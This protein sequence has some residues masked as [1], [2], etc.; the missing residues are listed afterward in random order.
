MKRSYQQNCALAHALD[1]V[2]ERW[3]LLIVRELLI[4]PRRYGQLLDNLRGIGT[5]LLAD[6]LREMEARGLVEKH[7]QRYSLT[8]RGRQL[9]AVVFELVR[10]GLTLELED[11]EERLTRPEWDVVALNSLY[12]AVD[13]DGLGGRYVIELNASPFCIEGAGRDRV[14][15]TPGDCADADLRVSL[16]KKLARQLGN[17][18]RSFVDATRDG[19][20]RVQGS[21]REARRLLRSF[22]ILP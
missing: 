20:L 9:E 14:R 17:G 19:S 22:G 2:G 1:L 6:R 10:F 21:K 16:S 15:V 18:A 3:T 12:R 8:D 4:G 7:A 5:N 11:S 13:D